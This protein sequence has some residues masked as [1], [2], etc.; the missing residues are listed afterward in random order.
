MGAAQ[1]TQLVVKNTVVSLRWKLLDSVLTAIM[2]GLGKLRLQK[3]KEKQMLE[4]IRIRESVPN[5]YWG[6]GEGAG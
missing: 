2:W 5:S 6:T 1:R 4:N 3:S